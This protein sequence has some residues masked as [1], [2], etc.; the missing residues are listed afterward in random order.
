MPSKCTSLALTSLPTGLTSIGT[1]AFHG[2]TSLALTSLPPGLT[3]I[4]TNAFYGCTSLAL[5]SLPTG[6]ASIGSRPLA[7]RPSTADL[8]IARRPSSLHRPA[9][10]NHD[11]RQLSLLRM[12]LAGAHDPAD[13]NH[14][15]RQQ[16]LQGCTSL[17]LTAPPTGVT[18][19]GVWAF[20]CS[21]L[22]WLLVPNGCSVG[23]DAFSWH[24]RPIPWLRL[25]RLRHLLLL[26]TAHTSTLTAAL[27]TTALAA[28]P[29]LRP[30]I[31]RSAGS[32]LF[33][34]ESLCNERGG[35]LAQIASA[36]ANGA[37][38]AAMPAGTIAWIGG[39]E[40]EGG[41]MAVDKRRHVQLQ[42]LGDGRE[43]E[44]HWAAMRRDRL[45]GRQMA[46]A[47][48]LG[49]SRKPHLPG[50]S[51]TAA[52]AAAIAAA[53]LASPSPPSPPP[54]HRRR[55]LHRCRPLRHRRHPRRRR[56]RRHHPRR[57]LRCRH[58]LH[59]HLRRRHHRHLSTAAVAA[60]I[61]ATLSTAITTT[62]VAAAPATASF[63][64]SRA[65]PPL[66]PSLCA[67]NAV[68]HSRR[69]SLPLPTTPS[70]PPCRRARSLGLVAKRFRNPN[71]R[72]TSGG[73]SFPPTSGPNF[74]YS[75]WAS[76]ESLNA[77]GLQCAAID[78]ADGKWRALD[79]SEYRRNL[80]CQEVAPPPPSPP[81]PPP[82]APPPSAPPPPSPSL[83][84]PLP[85]PPA[86]SP[87]VTIQYVLAGGLAAF[88]T[89]AFR[90]SLQARF[91]T[92]INVAVSAG[93]VVADVSMYFSTEASAS[94]AA[95]LIRKHGC[96]DDVRRMVL[97]AQ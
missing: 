89:D 39:Q 76:G 22:P 9:D 3:S 7:T 68:A 4:G 43:P 28:T 67:T 42:Q 20:G 54:R 38:V 40:T 73:G 27:A 5:T 71:W 70:S 2:C 63:P 49:K 41:I 93:S 33:S 48:L 37:I 88:D 82:S 23:T 69:S 86:T 64:S 74:N 72:W 16:C 35:T 97:A 32:H 31:P 8:T 56:P 53:T 95:D 83:P 50:D 12:H 79:C 25:H 13:R 96:C 36:A 57:R 91:S 6:I 26:A 24:N 81:S 29:R 65:A 18:S 15:H 14:V 30:R 61:T 52:I 59:R 87:E 90:A 47:R 66:K 77:T 80:V 46:R 1:N 60:A 62:A 94:D 34:S 11:H 44:R 85:P 58:P 92:T 19:I 21:S 51:A 55:R 10:R 75:N 45:G 84:P 78:S 17:A